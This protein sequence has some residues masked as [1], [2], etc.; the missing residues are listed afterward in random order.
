MSAD[1]G[2]RLG[3]IISSLAIMGL[4]KSMNSGA[5]RVKK[6]KGTNDVI[7]LLFLCMV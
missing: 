6:K 4:T 3:F 2:C 1:Y 5:N 7:E